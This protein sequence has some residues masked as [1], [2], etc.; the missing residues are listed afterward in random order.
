[1]QL[2][3]LSKCEVDYKVKKGNIFRVEIDDGNGM[4]NVCEDTINSDMVIE[5]VMT[6]S[7]S[8]LEPCGGFGCYMGTKKSVEKFEQFLD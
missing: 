3:K 1:M 5:S 2:Q 6:F 4:N 7:D 8:W